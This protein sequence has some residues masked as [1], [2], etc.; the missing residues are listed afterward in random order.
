MI[1]Q[2][3]TIYIRLKSEGLSWTGFVHSA[4]TRI[5]VK[6]MS[7]NKRLDL[8]IATPSLYLL[9]YVHCLKELHRISSLMWWT[10][11]M[12]FT[13]SLAL[14][15]LRTDTVWLYLYYCH[16]IMH[17]RFYWHFHFDT[18]RLFAWLCNM[19]NSQN[20]ITDCWIIFKRSCIVRVM[21]VQSQN[22]SILCQHIWRW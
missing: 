3:Q 15:F 9:F 10:K 5:K 21:D 14:P 16:S 19:F 4:S 13:L 18:S 11:C 2:G 8:P 22:L 20:I 6:K 1:W 17:C 12:V 7:T